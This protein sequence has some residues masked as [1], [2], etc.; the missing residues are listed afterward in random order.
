MPHPCRG[1]RRGL[2]AEPGRVTEWKPPQGPNIRLDSHCHTGYLVP[3]YHDSMIGKL[4][5]YGSDREEALQ[6]MRQALARFRISGIGTTLAFL[7]HV[8]ADPDFASGRSG[9]A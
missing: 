5:V 7:R 1:A 3:P 8:M 4:I 9:S 2:L 6:R